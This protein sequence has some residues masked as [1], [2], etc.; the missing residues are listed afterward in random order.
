MRCRGICY[1][2]HNPV[3]TNNLTL[4]VI[5]NVAKGDPD[6]DDGAANAGTGLFC[7]FT[8]LAQINSRQSTLARLDSVSRVDV[9]E[10]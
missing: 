2:S 1:R 10:R 4:W 9:N 5:Q 3:E 6:S 7:I 8:P